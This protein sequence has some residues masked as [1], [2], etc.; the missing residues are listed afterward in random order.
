MLVCNPLYGVFSGWGEPGRAL[1]VQAF[2]SRWKFFKLIFINFLQYNETSCSHCRH[3]AHRA[4][5]RSFLFY[6]QAQGPGRVG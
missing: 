2:E 6:F 3:R 1:R 4:G 5:C